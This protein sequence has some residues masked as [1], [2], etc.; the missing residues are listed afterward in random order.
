MAPGHFAT[1]EYVPE[2]A[3][4]K[5]RD[6]EDF[7]VTSTVPLAFSTALHA[8]EDLACL[9]QGQSVLIHSAT[10]GVGVAAVQ[11]AQL[12]RA[13][14]YATVGT[15]EK[16][17]FLKENFGIP[18]DHIFSS[19]DDSFYAGIMKATSDRGVDV[20]LNSLTGDLLHTS[21]QACAEF[22][23]F[24]EIGKRDI[25]DGGHLNMAIFKK[26]TTFTSFDLTNLYWSDREA[27]RRT[28]HR[29]G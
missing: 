11:I 17:Q 28:W 29:Y 13:E 12:L 19:H 27:K 3:C 22:G 10:G 8:F 21:W 4:Y 5:L 14:I 16:R 20:V 23:T 9:E 24:I 7:A 1:L 15:N 2:W 6:D 26:N 25:S 18:D